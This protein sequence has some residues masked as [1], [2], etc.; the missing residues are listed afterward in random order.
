[1]GLLMNGLLKIPMQFIILS[2]GVLVFLFYQF[3]TQPIFHNEHVLHAVLQ[4]SP[5][6]IEPIIKKYENLQLKKQHT[7]HQLAKQIQ[8]QEEGKINQLTSDYQQF[9]KQEEEYRSAFKKELSTQFPASKTDDRDFMFLN[10]VLHQLPHGLIGLLMA[11][12]FSAAMGSLASELNALSAT[13]TIDFYKRHWRPNASDLQYVKASKW[14]TVAW[15]FV[16]LGF[17]FMASQQSENLIQFVNIVGSL[18]YGTILGI[19]L[20]AFYIPYIKA[21]AVFYA[22]IVAELL[23]LCC[24][25]YFGNRVAFLYYNIIG[26]TTVLVFGVLGQRFFGEE[27]N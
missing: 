13:S 15:A 24:Y 27:K 6:T 4:K 21:N 25:Y 17:A 2:I 5:I 12:I 20:A 8:Q 22:A 26:C 3:N 18:F 7:V 10:F 23:V 19:F 16:A 9:S 11:V 1:M 14:L